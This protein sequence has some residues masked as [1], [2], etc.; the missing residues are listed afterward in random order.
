MGAWDIAKENRIARREA[1]KRQMCVWMRVWCAYMP[2]MRC[3]RC[4][5]ATKRDMC[6]GECFGEDTNQSIACDNYE[7]RNAGRDRS[8]EARNG[9]MGNEHARDMYIIL[10][11]E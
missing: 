8:V 10:C 7:Q 4:R 9:E 5:E 11:V 1:Q 2:K 6:N 3:V